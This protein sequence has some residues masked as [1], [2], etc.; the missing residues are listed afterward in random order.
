LDL[1]VIIGITI[2]TEFTEELLIHN[3]YV[4]RPPNND[5]HQQRFFEKTL[6]TSEISGIFDIARNLRDI[7]G[8]SQVDFV[9]IIGKKTTKW[10]N[11]K[12]DLPH[13]FILLVILL[14]SLFYVEQV[15]PN[16]LSIEEAVAYI[17]F[18]LLTDIGYMI[19]HA[20]KK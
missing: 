17:I 2:N 4:N 3:G 7:P 5:L 1:I 10:Q 6:E 18:P 11:F 15:H 8:I 13:V 14:G 12:Q 19:Y 9:R 20:F 16:V